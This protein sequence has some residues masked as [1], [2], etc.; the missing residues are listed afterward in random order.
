MISSETRTDEALKVAEEIATVRAHLATL[1]EKFR[2]LVGG[3]MNGTAVTPIAP[4]RSDAPQES[5]TSRILAIFTRQPGKKIAV[6]EVV[7]A[8]PDID[9]PLVRSTITRL[10]RT[11]KLKNVRRGIYKAIPPPTQ[12]AY[13]STATTA[14]GVKIS[15]TNRI[16]S[17]IERNP[18][19][20]YG[21]V[22]TEI[23]GADTVANR[24]RLRSLL[25]SLATNNRITN[26]GPNKWSV[27]GL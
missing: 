16:L 4:T 27:V 1:M 12:T 14:V 23:Y 22:S 13:E 9:A 19:L 2:V 5:A 17:M 6:H 26:V 25:S 15:N 8:L 11:E 3:P 20:D 18:L 10:G 21:Q 7:A 24:K